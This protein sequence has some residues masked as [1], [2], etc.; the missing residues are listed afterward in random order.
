M[1]I[2]KNKKLDI[3]FRMENGASLFNELRDISSKILK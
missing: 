2:K 1:A 3:W